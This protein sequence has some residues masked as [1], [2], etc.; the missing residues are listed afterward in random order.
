MDLSKRGQNVEKAQGFRNLLV[1]IRELTLTCIFPTHFN[2]NCG[3]K[4]DKLKF[5]KL[6]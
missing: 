3:R 5:D 6:K 2:V 4:F 1:V